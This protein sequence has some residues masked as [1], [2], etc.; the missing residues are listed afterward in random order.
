MKIKELKTSKPKS[1]KMRIRKL[2]PVYMFFVPAIIFVFIFGYLPMFTNIIAFMDYDITQGWLGLG[3]PFVGFK[4]FSFLREEWF[5]VLAG[6]TLLYTSTSLIFGFPASLILALLFNELRGSKFKKTV[7]T[8][9]YIPNF[10]SWVTVAGLTYMFLTVEPEGI[11]NSIRAALFQAEPISYMQSPKYFL[12]ILVLTGVWK[13]VGWGTI[14]YMAA[15]TAIS[16]E[17]YE[18]A[19]VDGASRWH[20]TRYITIPSLIPTMCILLIFNLGGLFNNNFDQIFNLQNAVIRQ[21]VSTINLYTY[22]NG[23]VNRQYSLTTAVGLFQG[24]VSFVLI[25]T[26]NS[27]TKKLSNTGIF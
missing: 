14:I 9:S 5:Y 11:F 23:V 4:W 7:Q 21:D 6:R 2:L 8:I 19:M 13:G 17:I 26:T 1:N 16:E 22:F 3:S 10:V 25:Y 15:L 18:A 12:P 24:L 27:V 20:K